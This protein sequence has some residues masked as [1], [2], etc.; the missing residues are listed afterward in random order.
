MQRSANL[1]APCRGGESIALEARIIP[2]CGTEKPQ[3]NQRRREH[4]DGTVPHL[5]GSLR[6]VA[7]IFTQVAVVGGGVMLAGCSNLV[8]TGDVYEYVNIKGTVLKPQEIIDAVDWDQALVFEI[9]IRQN[10]FRP[11]IV[12]LFQGEPYIMVIENRDDEEHLFAAPE[13]FKTTAIRKVVTEKEE[14]KGVNLIALNLKPGE[15]KEVH[16][17]PVR[18][19][20]YDFEGGEP[21][22]PFPGLFFTGFY[23]SPFSRGAREGMI[24][25]FVVEQ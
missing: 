20:W 1:P 8:G 5:L 25:S 23:R 6:R 14:I 3:A 19:G 7:A 15:I 17:V 4:M 21:G 13:F 12:H 10:E 24:G 2:I 11:M 16:F 9:D 22:G 18:D